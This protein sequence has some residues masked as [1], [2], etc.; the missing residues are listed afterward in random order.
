VSAGNEPDSNAN[1][2][3]PYSASA[4]AT[5][6][7]SYFGPGLASSNVK[8]MAPET[9]NWCGFPSYLAALESNTSAWGY[10]QIVATHEYGC[11]PIAATD[12]HVAQIASAGKEFWETEIYDLN[13]N[14]A[15]PGMPSA[16]RVAALIHNALTVSNMNAWHYW[17]LYDAHNGGLYDTT[18]N[19]W[20][21]RLW[22][23]GNY[24]RFVRPGFKRV[25]TSG[26]VP[27]GVLMT[28]YTN[29]ADGTVVVVAINNGSGT[30]SLPIFIS[31]SAPCTMTPYET[32]SGNNLVAKSPI[33]VTAGRF[34]GSLPGQ[35]V[36]TFVGKP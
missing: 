24:S 33:T 20:A 23:M 25:A 15:D 30:A 4:M 35:S 9:E 3:A 18:N 11:N 31:G 21:Q 16:L 36:T 8:L 12:S 1:G 34:T 32:S 6:V 2:A 22:V 7:G 14:S 26:T 13:N 17:W 28:A 5:W 27:S 19:V 29:S 10:V